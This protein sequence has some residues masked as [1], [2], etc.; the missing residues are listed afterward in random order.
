[1]RIVI[2]EDEPLTAEDL[3]S[4]LLDVDAGIEVVA[5]LESVVEAVGYF[6]KNEAPDLIFSDIQLSDGL[7]F[8]LFKKVPL[9]SPV[10]FCTA[11]D[12]YAIQAFKANGIDYIMKP[13]GREAISA[14]LERFQQLKDRFANQNL[15]YEV[16]RKMFDRKEPSEQAS[17]LV[18]YKDQIFPIRLQDVALFYLQNE[19]THLTTFKGEHY[20]LDNHLDYLDQLTGSGF[21]RANRQY[22]VNR[23]A[24]KSASRFFGRKLVIS[25]LVTHKN[26]IVVSKARVPVFLNWLSGN[27]E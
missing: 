23:K 24:I 26:P 5:L 13:F 11:Y 18:Y 12:E 8:E 6:Q 22:L 9:S 4:T 3:A 2:I 20:T 25:V 19:V 10:I 7:S 21:F 1:M 15:S 17:V 16:L 27:Q 14:A